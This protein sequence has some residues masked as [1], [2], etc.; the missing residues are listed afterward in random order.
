MQGLDLGLRGCEG[1]EIQIFFHASMC[2]IKSSFQNKQEATEGNCSF[3]FC[4]FHRIH[5]SSC[6]TWHLYPRPSSSQSQQTRL[7][8][9]LSPFYFLFKAPVLWLQ[10]VAIGVES[11]VEANEQMWP[12]FSCFK[13]EAL[14]SQQTTLTERSTMSLMMSPLLLFFFKDPVIYKGYISSDYVLQ[15]IYTEW[16]FL[17]LNCKVHVKQKAGVKGQNSSRISN[18]NN[19]IQQWGHRGLHFIRC[20]EMKEVACSSHEVSSIF[21]FTL[22]T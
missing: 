18:I 11:A 16:G 9:I 5:F 7:W 13:S 3:H 2:L 12:K 17:A 4:S 1:E 10:I 8:S 21:F 20:S 22:I 15:P 19:N 14:K 6:H